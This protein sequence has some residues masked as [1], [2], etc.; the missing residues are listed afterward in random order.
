MKNTLKQVQGKSV[1][2]MGGVLPVV[3]CQTMI[4]C[5]L[6]VMDVKLG[7]CEI[8]TLKRNDRASSVDELSTQDI[9]IRSTTTLIDSKISCLASR[10]HGQG[11]VVEEDP[12]VKL[13]TD[14]VI[15]SE[16]VVESLGN[17]MKI[18]EGDFALIAAHAKMKIVDCG[19]SKGFSS[20]MKGMT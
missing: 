15:I 20:P 18:R 8:C 2:R 9:G 7:I 17:V 16:E 13:L 12:L 6:S 11:I 19:G 10:R 14:M 3:P 5:M 1:K 4:S